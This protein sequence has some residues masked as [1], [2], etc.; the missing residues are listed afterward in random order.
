MD[1]HCNQLD[2]LEKHS[3][4]KNTN[5]ENSLVPGEIASVLGAYTALLEA[6]NYRD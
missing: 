3:I 6:K 4:R 1:R 5:R 2:Y